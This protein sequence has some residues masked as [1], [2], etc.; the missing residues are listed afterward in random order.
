MLICCITNTSR[1][2]DHAICCHAFIFY[3]YFLHQKGIEAEWVV[4][5]CVKHLEFHHSEVNGWMDWKKK[6]KKGKR[7]LWVATGSN[8]WPMDY[9]TITL[10]NWASNPWLFSFSFCF[11][12]FFSIWIYLWLVVLLIELRLAEKIIMPLFVCVA[13]LNSALSNKL[14]ETTSSNNIH[15]NEVVWKNTHKC[16]MFV[17]WLK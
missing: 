1:M 4:C 15:S 7:E 3:L 8:C 5:V 2:H 9:E 11:F 6:R 14:T 17:W 13:V 12:F 16:Q 10:T